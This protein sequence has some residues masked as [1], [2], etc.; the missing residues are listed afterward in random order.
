MLIDSNG[1]PVIPTMNI[2]VYKIKPEK[3]LIPEDILLFLKTLF[4]LY[5]E[6]KRITSI[7]D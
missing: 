6:K 5:K 4:Y 7:L 3:A 2:K 1:F